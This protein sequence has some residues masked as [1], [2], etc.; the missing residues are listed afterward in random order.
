MKFDLLSTSINDKIILEANAAEIISDEE[1]NFPQ[2]YTNRF[3]NSTQ[4]P[5]MRTTTN[6]RR[7]LPDNK[8]ITG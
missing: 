1:H 4:E 2:N 8:D 3:L 6:D 7:N 5:F